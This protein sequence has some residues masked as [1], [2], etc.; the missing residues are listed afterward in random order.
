MDELLELGVVPILV[1]P[2]DEPQGM[3]AGANPGRR[4]EL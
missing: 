4:L 1:G 3:G 2:I